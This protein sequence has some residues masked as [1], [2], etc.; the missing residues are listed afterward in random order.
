MKHGNATI[1][2]PIDFTTA[3][4]G[5]T[6]ITAGHT[7]YMRGGTYAGDFICL[8]VG[9]AEAPV[10]IRPYPGEHVIIDGGISLRGQHV[11]MQGV[12][13]MWS[14]WTHRSD[15]TLD[16]A[17]AQ[18]DDPER[19]HNAELRGVGN[20]FIECIIHDG[21]NTA[22]WIS[23]VGGGYRDCLIYNIGAICSTNGVPGGHG[24]CLYTQNEFS[25]QTHDNII[26]W[27]AFNFGFH[28]YTGSGLVDNFTV[29]RI[30]SYMNAARNFA[31]GG[32]GGQRIHTSTFEEICTYPGGTDYYKG[33]N[34]TFTDCYWGGRGLTV[35]AAS[36]DN[37]YT[38]APYYIE[39]E[40]MPAEPTEG[41]V[42][43]TYACTNPQRAHVAVFN[44]D[45][46]DSAVVNLSA[47]VGISAGDTVRVRNAQNYFVDYDDLTVSETGTITVDMRAA[48]HSVAARVDSETVV[49]TS[50]PKFGAFIVEKL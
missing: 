39:G 22:S 32:L 18:G 33:S 17:V 9:T 50:F 13:I 34:S 8:L 44:W 23:N 4:S 36:A 26:M 14:G 30:I 12:E 43:K 35:Q 25:T 19:S 40:G 31:A 10:V 42:I 28:A 27:G 16:Y 45:Q 15:G 48:N 11:H 3:I 5:V 41:Q 47:V 20:Q 38:N 46:A 7:V 29:S 24:H 49:A 2:Y 1:T 6:G 21:Y 37:T